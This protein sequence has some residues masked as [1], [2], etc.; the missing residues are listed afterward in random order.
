LPKVNKLILCLSNFSQPEFD[1][2]SQP[3]MDKASEMI[4]SFCTAGA[5]RTMA[6]FNQ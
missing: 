6:Q 5:E 2:R 1:E 3:V 4:F